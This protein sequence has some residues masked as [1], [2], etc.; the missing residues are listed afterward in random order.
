MY[1]RGRYTRQPYTRGT[2]KLI[3]EAFSED[4]L[5][6]ELTEDSTL[7]KYLQ[8]KQT[9]DFLRVVL[10]DYARQVIQEVESEDLL[11]L[12]LSEIATKTKVEPV[13]KTTSDAL[14]TSIDDPA[15]L[16][17]Y[18]QVK[19]ASDFARVKL[20]EGSFPQPLSELSPEVV[21]LDRTMKQVTTL[22]WELIGE[23]IRRQDYHTGEDTLEFVY[24]TNAVDADDLKEGYTVIIRD[25]DSNFIPYLVQDIT[26]SIRGANTR[27]V[28]CEHLFYELAQGPIQTY[29]AGNVFDGTRWQWGTLPEGFIDT[30]SDFYIPFINPLQWIRG[31]EMEYDYRFTFRV[32]IGST[33]ISSYIVDVHEIDNE[34]KGM[35]FEL[36][37]SVI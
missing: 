29:G 17:K 32:E 16:K 21:I 14:I 27:K 7:K 12:V 1:T 6:L 34:F 33:G 28:I 20:T 10:T 2:G 18:L 30:V 23:P 37:R 4:T 35:E 3:H 19:R 36:G 5:N 8:R 31:V 11:T 13:K 25:E 15:S 9:S 22:P 24:P 26:L